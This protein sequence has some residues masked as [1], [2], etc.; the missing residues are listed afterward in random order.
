[1][2]TNTLTRFEIELEQNK[3]PGI[4]NNF[5]YKDRILAEIAEQ[6]RRVRLFS[7]TPFSYLMDVLPLLLLSDTWVIEHIT[8]DEEEKQQRK[9][10]R[11]AEKLKK[12]EEESKTKAKAKA[13]ASDE[14]E[15]EDEEEADE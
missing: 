7:S 15:D 8:Q 4:P 5:P 11:K 10:Q 2:G 14:D 12:K 1:M 13:E 9:E 3:D 6:R